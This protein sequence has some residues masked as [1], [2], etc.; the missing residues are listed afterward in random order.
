[1]MVTLYVIIFRRYPFSN[2]D[3]IKRCQ[4]DLQG[5]Q[6]RISEDLYDLLSSTLVREPCQRLTMREIQQHDWLQQPFHLEAYP[7]ET[8]T[9]NSLGSIFLQRFIFVF[10]DFSSI[11]RTRKLFR[12]FSFRRNIFN[13][14]SSRQW[15]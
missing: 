14:K 13:G 5:F 3:E 2:P 8:V 6:S 15:R 12:E 4:L 10:F 9:Q 1:M 7:W 11:Q